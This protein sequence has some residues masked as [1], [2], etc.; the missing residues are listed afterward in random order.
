MKQ[1][2]KRT[3]GILLPVSSLPS[4]Y[5]IGTLGSAAY[6]FVD[7]LVRAGQS[8][9]QVLPVGPTGFGDSPYQPFSAFAGNPY[10]IDLDIL[11]LSGLLTQK[12]IDQFTPGKNEAVVNYGCLYETR[13]E[14]LQKAFDRFDTNDKAYLVFCREKSD[15]LDDYAL[16]M[17]VK[18]HF[19]NKDYGEWDDDIRLR[20]PEAM[21]RYR[22]LL[23]G[24]IEFW[25]VCQCLFYSQWH[26]LK[27]YANEQ[28]IALFGDIP[29]YV[30]ADGADVWA[31]RQLFQM[32][33]DGRPS[34]I[35]G[36]P[37]D[38]F[39]ETGQR[40]GNP[41]YDW[42]AMERDGFAW[43]KKRIS[44]CAE[45]FDII[46]ID[47]FIGIA[48]YYSINPSCKT[49]I[50]GVWKEGPGEKLLNALNDAIGD[51]RIVAEDLGV[52][53][54]SVLELLDRSGYPG[55]KVL[56]FAADGAE[57]NPHI[58]YKFTNNTTVY[59]GT[60][61]NDT[62][63][64]FCARHRKEELKYLLEYFGVKN[65]RSL[66]SALIRA[67]LASVADTAIIQMQDWLEIGNTARTNTPSTVGENWKWR[68][69]PTTLTEEL[70]DKVAHLT[71][72]YGR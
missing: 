38:Y 44:M 17:A 27:Q 58:P 31:N 35:A 45:L 46:R 29:I 15:W 68:L 3:A 67:A 62:A 7:F 64:G 56:L 9:W 54:P 11:K 42:Q 14:L 13:F 23:A 32:G 71:R 28:G 65:K 26:R 72:L 30:S 19:K 52:L 34:A 69:A 63:V 5:G 48:R 41:L 18:E 36:V 37:P 60:H 70:A 43:W 40:W 8:I 33:E 55:M 21:E 4:A 51:A 25:R 2:V 20:E 53:H 61:D 22:L 47:H 12:E 16:F 24:R 66:P 6:D 49:A 1:Q 57:D 50:G 39:S 59:V 10:F